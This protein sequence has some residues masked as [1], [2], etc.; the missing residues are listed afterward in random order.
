MW[1]YYI[2]LFTDRNYGWFV[3]SAE[4][5]KEL[6]L[7]CDLAVAIWFNNPEELN[8]WVKNNIS[9]LDLNNCDYGIKGVYYPVL[10]NN[11]EV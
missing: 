10:N 11:E 2:E 8:L 7:C 9:I 6:P 1:K 5:N 3:E 4:I